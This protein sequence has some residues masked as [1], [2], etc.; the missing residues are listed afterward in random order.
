[1]NFGHKAST[2]AS[3]S[4]YYPADIHFT[5]STTLAPPTANK[6][7]ILC[8]LTNFTPATTPAISGFGL[9]PASSKN[10]MPYSLS[11]AM[12]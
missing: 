7:S 10:L 12:I 9:S 5:E 2:V 3:Q 1:M 4:N 8:Y 6:A 11:F